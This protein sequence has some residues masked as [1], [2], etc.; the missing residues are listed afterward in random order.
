MERIK[1]PGGVTY[2]S[3]GGLFPAFNLLGFLTLSYMHRRKIL[4]MEDNEDQR[5]LLVYRLRKL[6]NYELRVATDGGEALSLLAADPP[7]LMF[8]DLQVV[9]QSWL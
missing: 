9:F 2:T 7:D 1:K 3:R 6:S 8:L 5:H 4:V